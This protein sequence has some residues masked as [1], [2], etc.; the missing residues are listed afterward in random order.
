MSTSSTTTSTAVAISSS[1]ADT[2]VSSAASVS[3]ANVANTA[4]DAFS[5]FEAEMK[6]RKNNDGKASSVLGRDVIPILSVTMLHEVGKYITFK[7]WS[8]LS[9]A[10][11]KNLCFSNFQPYLT[12]L[13]KYVFLNFDNAGRTSL[14]HHRFELLSDYQKEIVKPVLPQSV[15]E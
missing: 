10:Q 3:A 9:D 7:E 14:N 5:K 13:A 12:N 8:F 2:A 6:Y 15:F 1:A 11:V 4:L